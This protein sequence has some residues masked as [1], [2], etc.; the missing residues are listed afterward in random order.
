MEPLQP[1]WKE[2]EPFIKPGEEV[3]KK[4]LLMIIAYRVSYYLYNAI[5]NYVQYRVGRDAS[6]EIYFY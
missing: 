1:C 6:G 5:K 3:P 2:L 4:D